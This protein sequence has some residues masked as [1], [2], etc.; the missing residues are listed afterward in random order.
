MRRTITLLEDLGL[1]LA[2]IC[3]ALIMF[4]VS[5]DAVSRYA[6]HAPLPWAF[7]L[8]TYYLMIGAAYLGVSAT[9]REGDHIAI[10]LFRNYMSP[11]I[12]A[13][14]D[15][16]WSLLAAVIFGVIAYGAWE[17]MAG[18]LE[19]N[20]FLPGYITWPAW[21]SYL[22]IVAGFLLLAVR[23]VVFAVSMILY[24][25][26]RDVAEHSTKSELEEHHE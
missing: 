22:P 11:G 18:A 1:W 13:A 6:L 7:E 17:E 16:I 23:L 19:R 20:E 10:D 5:Y 15:V 14:S 2:V 9:F 3:V 26:D 4:I 24:G 21:L 8:I 25:R 12:R